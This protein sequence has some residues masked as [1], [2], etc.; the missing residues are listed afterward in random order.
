MFWLHYITFLKINAVDYLIN[1]IIISEF[2]TVKHYISALLKNIKNEKCS[3]TK[4]LLHNAIYP[5]LVAA[6]KPNFPY[7]WF[8]SEFSVFHAGQRV[9]GGCLQTGQHLPCRSVGDYQKWAITR[10]CNLIT[11]S[12]NEQ[13][14]GLLLQEK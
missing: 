6:L 11:F 4:A 9:K 7:F 12:S 8:V 14:K 5:K 2:S 3:N 13:S 1:C 10:Y